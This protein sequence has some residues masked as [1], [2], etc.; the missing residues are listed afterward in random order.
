MDRLTAPRHELGPLLA[1]AL[2]QSGAATLTIQHP[3]GPART[4][5]PR[6]TDLPALLREAPVGTTLTTESGCTITLTDD[7]CTF[8][9]PSELLIEAIGQICR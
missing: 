6:V 8:F 1:T 5:T 2:A 7:G 9:H 3:A 4:L